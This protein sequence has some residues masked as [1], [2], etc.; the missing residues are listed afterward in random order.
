MQRFLEK[1]CRHISE[2]HP[3]NLAEVCI[4]LPNRRA[5]LFLKKIFP[6]I[7]GKTTWSPEIFSI[8]DF[9]V[10]L[11]GY[12]PADALGLLFDFY[13]IHRRIEGEKAQPFDEFLQWGQLLLKDIN[14]IDMNLVDAGALFGY[15]TEV[16]AIEKWNPGSP[17]L[18]ELMK[19]YLRF[20]RSLY[21]YYQ[22]LRSKAETTQEAHIGFIYR[23][24]AE[25]IDSHPP[26]LP[27][28]R[29]YFAGFNA[30]TKA[31][32]KIT[33]ALIN[34]NVAEM[35]WDADEYYLTD[36][37]QEAGFF[38]RKELEAT[39][40]Q[41]F[42]WIDNGFKEVIK[43]IT[44]CG[45]PKNLGQ[46]K[47]AASVVK[48]WVERAESSAGSDKVGDA[49]TSTALVLA[50][51]NL[52]FQVLSSLDANTPPF[53]VTMG[54]PVKYTSAYQFF[55]LLFRLYENAGRFLQI[56]KGQSKG[57]Y[58]Q[59]ILKLL[60]HSFLSGYQGFSETALTIKQA[61]RVFYHPEQLHVF[62]KGL[63][64]TEKDIFLKIIGELTPAP[65][66]VLENI[67]FLLF[68]LRKSLGNKNLNGH[69]EDSSMDLEYLFHFSKIN[70]RL[71]GLIEKYQSV[72]RV[73]TLRKIFDQIVLTTKIPFEGEPL[74]GLQV[75]GTLETRTLNFDRVILLSA[76]E[77]ILPSTSFGNSFIP[78]D[79]QREFGLP[80]FQE[81]NAVFAYHF[82]RLIQ[83]AREVHL[84]YNTEPD[85]LGGGEPSRFIHQ[86]LLELPKYQ[87]DHKIHET[88]ISLPVPELSIPEEI[89]I[90]KEEDV[91][92]LLL[93]K[94]ASGLSPS[95][96][97]TYLSCPLKFY[98]REIAKI[99]EAEEVEENLEVQTMGSIVHK[100]L[101]ILYKP[102]INQLLTAELI[103]GMLAKSEEAIAVAIAENYSGGD[104]SFGRNR[105]LSEVIRNFVKSFLI[106]EKEMIQSLHNSGKHITLLDLEQRYQTEFGL[107]DA[108][109]IT[110]KLKGFIDRV[111]KLGD[112]VRIIDYKT[113]S[114]QKN[115]LTF[116]S[117]EAFTE[118]DKNGKAFQ[119]LMYAWLY[120]KNH[121]N[122]AAKFNSGVISMRKLSE[123]L[124]NFAIKPGRNDYPDTLIDTEKLDQFEMLMTE[125]LEEIFDKEIPFTQTEELK[126]CDYCEFREMCQR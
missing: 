49:L 3:G 16:K 31:E 57:F 110:V 19:N 23:Q 48:G 72:D 96:I 93:K 55:N 62:T 119:V 59:D 37:N 65:A 115:E 80:V 117:W 86:L 85:A 43:E 52:L 15:L 45:T 126:T 103:A 33:S 60:Q 8:E 121:P 75:M 71:R 25:V 109:N 20:Y 83:N 78:L 105:L 1:V 111:D 88:V 42:K 13:E 17:Q 89:S 113:G 50:D 104:I 44:I 58:Y 77:G 68:E 125:I 38:L 36:K 28:K 94:G 47:Y 69:D 107:P 39:D 114:V 97:N 118:S 14:E 63:S 102:Y 123:G 29:I 98:F 53:N 112:V 7:T 73:K 11:S 90:P 56:D 51:E 40:K 70:T 79:I 108:G 116:P 41:H 76:N 4:V 30:L 21:D 106:N 32:K 34:Q 46:A 122:G 10:H 87:P 24:L 124:M 99:S 6:E 5:G 120:Q 61:N 100:A 84:V 22:A 2:K 92:E 35:L 91:F 101:E 66:K 95:S 64:E 27:W 9:C 26:T 12:R 67:E 81:K 82:Y 74:H 54:F 18:T